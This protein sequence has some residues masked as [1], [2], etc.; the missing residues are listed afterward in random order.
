MNPLA[1]PDVHVTDMVMSTLLYCFI[2]V[3]A[4][5]SLGVAV[6]LGM[7]VESLR[8]S[9]RRP[10]LLL[11]SRTKEDSL[12]LGLPHRAVRRACRRERAAQI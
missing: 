2:V 7:M 8:G 11:T 4:L 6:Y 5:L 3:S 12:S 9:D 10:P 1:T